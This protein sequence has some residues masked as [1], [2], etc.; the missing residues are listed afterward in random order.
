[1]DIKARINKMVE[2]ANSSV[3]AYASASFDGAFAVHGIKVF[4]GSKGTFVA[5]P[6]TG[7]T[8]KNGEKKYNDTFHPISKEAR[9]QLNSAVLKEYEAQLNQSQAPVQQNPFTGE[10][11]ELGDMSEFEDFP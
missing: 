11:C 5:M 3:K 4:E 9:E 6:S 8:D 1:M 10:P 7:Y 2:N